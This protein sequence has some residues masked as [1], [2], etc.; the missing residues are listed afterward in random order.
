MTTAI[1]SPERMNTA[2]FTFIN[3]KKVID[4][5]VLKY[6]SEH[7]RKRDILYNVII[8]IFVKW[9]TVLAQPP[10]SRLHRAVDV[11][12]VESKTEK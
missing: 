4:L 3:N 9:L 11:D 1:T 10:F 12:D 5:R 7:L 6:T 2:N 8:C